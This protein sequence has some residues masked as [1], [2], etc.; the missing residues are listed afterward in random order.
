MGL[1]DDLKSKLNLRYYPFI[2][3][4]LSVDKTLRDMHVYLVVV[5]LFEPHLHI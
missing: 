1:S 5:M 2:I 4:S 3:K